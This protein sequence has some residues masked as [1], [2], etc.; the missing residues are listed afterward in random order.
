MGG[1]AG[2]AGLFGT[3]TGVATLARAWLDDSIPGAKTAVTKRFWRLSDVVGSTRRVGW[4][5]PE[6]DGSASTGGALSPAASGHTGFTGTSLWIDPTRPTRII[7]LLSNAV[8][9]RRD[10]DAIR[11]FRPVFHRAAAR[12]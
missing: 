4:D 11:A 8:H 10:P 9:P 7:V 12:I 1:V 2:H 5:S 6:P 3:A